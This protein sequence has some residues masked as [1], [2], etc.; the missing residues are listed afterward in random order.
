MLKKL[1]I[2][3]LCLGLLFAFSA[4]G[5]KTG[6]TTTSEPAQTEPEAQSTEAPT[7]GRTPDYVAWEPYLD[8]VADYILKEEGKNY[9]ETDIKIPVPVVRFMDDT[10]KEN[11]KI[12]A[13]FIIDGFK[14]DGD[15]LVHESGGTSCGVIILK[16][17]GDSYSVVDYKTAE[18]GAHFEPTLK[19]ICEGDEDLYNKFI[20]AE[21]YK[22]QVEHD[23]ISDYVSKNN[24]KVTSYQIGEEVTP[25]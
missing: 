1:L 13:D 4:C 18:D 16:E 2:I 17:D 22:K 14:I 3:A 7:E 8:V 23:I 24:I 15:N 25:I 9:A 11:I 12:W 6:D 5:T 21:E 20:Y 19:E 10:D